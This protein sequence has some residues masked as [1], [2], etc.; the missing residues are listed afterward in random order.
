MEDMSDSAFCLVQDPAQRDRSNEALG[1]LEVVSEVLSQ[2]NEL[3]LQ[4]LQLRVFF[5][6][7]SFQAMQLL[8]QNYT[9]CL[10]LTSPDMQKMWQQALPRA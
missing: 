10:Y 6:N 5:C 2:L 8:L 9:C 1:H 3:L 7:L 4:P